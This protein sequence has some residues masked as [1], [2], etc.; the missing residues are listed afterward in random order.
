MSHHSQDGTLG[1]QLAK[2]IADPEL[3]RSLAKKEQ[4]LD[5]VGPTGTFPDGKMSPQDEGGIVFAVGG[6]GGKVTID[7]GK[8]VH[9]I[10]MTPHQAMGL[11]N[12]L[13]K[14]ARAANIIGTEKTPLTLEI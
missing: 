1:T 9:S 13:I 7:F 11:A 12:M 10:G 8:P 3:R 4:L 6:H 2:L 5:T 14:K